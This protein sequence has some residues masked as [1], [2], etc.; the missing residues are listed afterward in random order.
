MAKKDKKDKKEEEDDEEMED[1]NV[2]V[3]PYCKPLADG[4]LSKKL[5]KVIKK[6]ATVSLAALAATQDVLLSRSR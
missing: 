3:G 5:F 2:V 6:G 4:K 1:T